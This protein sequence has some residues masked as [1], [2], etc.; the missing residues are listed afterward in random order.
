MQSITPTCS[1]G[2]IPAVVC[3]GQTGAGATSLA[4]KAIERALAPGAKASASAA[5]RARTSGDSTNE[6]GLRIPHWFDQTSQARKDE[7]VTWT[8]RRKENG[9]NGHESCE[10]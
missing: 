2:D 1:S 4:W 9:R 5:T 6:D 8:P 3:P 7:G 10:K